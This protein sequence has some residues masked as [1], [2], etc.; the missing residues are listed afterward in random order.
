MNARI[1]PPSQ[2]TSEKAPGFRFFRGCFCR[3]LVLFHLRRNPSGLR[4]HHVAHPSDSS[5][6][7]KAHPHEHDLSNENCE[8]RRPEPPASDALPGRPVREGHHLRLECPGQYRD[9]CRLP[10][11]DGLRIRDPRTAYEEPYPFLL[12][13]GHLPRQH[14]HQGSR[15]REPH[16]DD[17]DARCLQ[18][19]Y[20]EPRRSR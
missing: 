16:S 18:R 14:R 2:K 15:G 4:P 5:A 13:R 10:G 8:G 9:P 3:A 6:K 17:R 20:G 7:L 12:R 19:L 11:W 1:L